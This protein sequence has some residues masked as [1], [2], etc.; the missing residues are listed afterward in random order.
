MLPTHMQMI[1]YEWIPALPFRL[2]GLYKSHAT[3]PKFTKCV[4]FRSGS[5]CLNVL[6]FLS[7]FFFLASCC[8]CEETRPATGPQPS[9]VEYF[10]CSVSTL[11]HAAIMKDKALSNEQLHIARSVPITN[12]CVWKKTFLCINIG[13]PQLAGSASPSG[14]EENAVWW[15]DT[16]AERTSGCHARPCLGQ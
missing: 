11:L 15:M 7:L 12:H 16:S 5:N 10:H 14:G 3:Q 8:P 9:E 2:R 1:I 13:A 4:D 6:V